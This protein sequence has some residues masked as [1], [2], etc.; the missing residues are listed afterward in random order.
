MEYINIGSRLGKVAGESFWRFGYKVCL[1][2]T[3]F[4]NILY[5]KLQRLQIKEGHY[6]VILTA[7]Q[8]A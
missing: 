7:N 3:V 8:E 6:D 1:V 5:D 2:T 4:Q